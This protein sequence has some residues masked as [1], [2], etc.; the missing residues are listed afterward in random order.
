MMIQETQIHDLIRSQPHSNLIS[1]PLVFVD[2]CFN[3]ASACIVLN[4][5][6]PVSVE[7]SVLKDRIFTPSYVVSTH[8]TSLKEGKT[9][10][11]V[12]L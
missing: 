6:Y 8:S 4:Q 11:V 12:S 3:F 10:R 9:K 2:V 5:R 1:S 7:I